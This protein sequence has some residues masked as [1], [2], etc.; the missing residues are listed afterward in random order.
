M[1]CIKNFDMSEYK[2]FIHDSVCCLQILKSYISILTFFKTL[3]GSISFL[4][5]APLDISNYLKA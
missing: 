3:Y 5:Y 2:F 4:I 1:Y